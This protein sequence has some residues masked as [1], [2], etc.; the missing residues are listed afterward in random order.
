MLLSVG[1]HGAN[2]DLLESIRRDL[3]KGVDSMTRADTFLLMCSPPSKHDWNE[4]LRKARDHIEI[5]IM[6]LSD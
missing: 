4:R 1:D 2:L 3:Y 6:M 5:N